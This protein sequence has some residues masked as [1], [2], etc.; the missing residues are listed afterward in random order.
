MQP[1]RNFIHYCCALNGRC[2]DFIP[3]YHDGVF[4]LFTIVGRNW[5][6]IITTDFVH[7]QE[8]GTA[9]YGGTDEEQ[10][11]CIYTGSVIYANGQFHIFYTGHNNF[12]AEQGKDPEVVMH[13]VSD[14]CYL[15]VKRPAF[16]IP[17][18]RTR[19]QNGGWRDPYVF[20]NEEAKEYWM[21]LTG[22]INEWQNKRWGCT[23]LVTSPD[24]EN[25]TIQDPLYAPHMY[26]SHECPDMFQMGDKWYLIFSTYTR[27]WE[28][29]YRISDSPNGP[30]HIPAEDNL[31]DGRAFYAAKTVSDGKRRFIVGWHSVRKDNSDKGTYEWGGCLDVHEIVQKPDGTLGVRLIREIESA[32]RQGEK[33]LPEPKF[34]FGNG[35]MECED[36]AVKLKSEG[37]SAVSLC[38]ADKV[39][40]IHTRIK[41]KKDTAA[42]GIIFRSEF[43]I[44]EKW[45]ALR[46]EPSRRRIVFDRFNKFFDDHYFD[47]ERPVYAEDGIYDIKIINDGTMIT[48][49]V[50]EEAALS[51]RCYEYLSGTVGLFVENGKARFSKIEVINTAEPQD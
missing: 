31:F 15:W 12:Y 19:Y 17:P 2:G 25:W 18:D 43:P 35:K 40:Y 11:Q 9:I 21:I 30:W 22:A 37:Y 50:N 5:D 4:H 10:D 8:V 47:E 34:E 1:D 24:L 7:F 36:G 14:D 28:T 32:M 20:Y 45:C 16:R 23:V 51:V 41:I 46:V 33:Q 42:A 6:H 29:H 3:F 38:E 44:F 26:D 39:S 27:W 13:A 48:C 49:Y